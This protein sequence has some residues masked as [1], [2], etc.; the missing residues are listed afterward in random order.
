[1]K[2]SDIVTKAR[3]AID[4][5]QLSD[6][7]RD[8]LNF[9][10]AEVEKQGAESKWITW[11]AAA[12]ERGV[13]FPSNPNGLV[14]PWLIGMYDEDP[15]AS[16]TAPLLNTVRAATVAQYKRDN[17]YVPPDF[18]KDSDMPDIDIDCLPS[19]RDKLK[20]YAIRKY[21]SNHNDEYGSVCSVGTWQT[22]K[23]RS[24]IIDTAVA[25]GAMDRYEAES[26]TT[27]LP[28]D[29][30]D[31]QEGGMSACK[32]TIYDPVTKESK[33][34]KK[35]HAQ[36]TCPKCGSPDT[37]GPTIG[38]ILAE[39]VQL[40][41]L[42]SK[43]P[44]VVDNAVEL[45]GRIRNMGMHAGA[46]II[47][48]RP[49]YGNIPL[50]KSGKKGFWASMWTEGRNA[51]LSK[52]GYVKWDLLGLKTLEYI[53]TACRL[54]EEN[55]GI[56]FDNMRGW[57]DID[58][59]NNR[60]GYFLD[61]NGVR[62][63][64]PL[65]NAGCFELIN[66]GQLVDSIFQLDT[67]LAKSTMMNGVSSFNDLTMLIA[68]GH[69]GPMQSIPE[70]VANRDDPKQS[71]RKKIDPKILPLLESTYGHICYQEQLQAM[72]QVLAGFTS[73][74]SQEA[75]KAVAKKWV[76]KLKGIEKKWLDGATPNI[77]RE[78]AE[79]WWMKM[80]TFGRYAFNLSHAVAYTLVT[81]RC[82]FLKRYFAPEWWAAV[83]SGCH[84]DKL[85]RY[86]GVARSER[87]NPTKDIT[88]SGTHKG[89]GKTKSVRFDTIN[90]ENLTIDFT[91]TGD[92]VNQ[93]LIG[94]KGIG[95]N[96]AMMFSGKGTY[97]DIDDFVLGVGHE[98]YDKL[99]KAYHDK[100]RLQALAKGK[101]YVEKPFSRKSKTVL[102]R[103]IKLGA[104]KNL[105]GHENAKALWLYYQY[106]HC[107]NSKLK[108]EVR[109]QL[110]AAEGWT[111]ESVELERERQ[112]DEFRF[113]YPKRTKIPKKIEEWKPKP[114]DSR[115]AIMALVK[116]DFAL[117]E[118]LEFQ[119]A[120]L[121]YYIDSPLD[122]YKCKGGCTVAD[123]KASATAEE[124]ARIEA[125][126]VDF[127]IAQ[128]KKEKDYG[129]LLITDGVQTALVMLWDLRGLD[130]AC[131]VPNVGITMFVN[132]DETRGNFTL[133]RGEAIYRLKPKV[134]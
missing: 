75:R 59:A 113:A 73:P 120:Y 71:W 126:V 33:E 36:V 58:P 26:Y 27:I 82:L 63:D 87:W 60:L 72:W 109:T 55:R 98:D 130:A 54:V 62:H 83:M 56:S 110:L 80:T 43:H 42:Y 61:A 96:A 21:G 115:Q 41:V 70:I 7:Y 107:N 46:L 101:Q 19:A 17:G 85:V 3:S 133:G 25:M 20:E 4:D 127:T 53:T 79:W 78:A 114:D 99:V 119:K 116:D 132:Y 15:L 128:T 102:E 5:R 111:P 50:A 52:F 13:K 105:P 6:I 23:F 134:K 93:G 49:L 74:E 108:S 88:Y 57:D 24:A 38:K 94:I 122:I 97:K 100:K 69:P 39:H 104:F 86:M 65:D 129:R 12:E 77:G 64:I 28:E 51:Q 44:D 48:D 22:Y 84:P 89:D 18:T 123:V 125:I 47:T 34:C 40:Q 95:D 124:T 10:I 117:E 8:R 121:G 81:M 68:L 1:M 11:A 30:D 45:V 91:V 66:N 2:W 35:K 16:R 31:L 90:I 9:E 118:K 106:A 131:L 14:L 103:F 76:H 92:V 29:V 37:E 67:D 112:I 32:G